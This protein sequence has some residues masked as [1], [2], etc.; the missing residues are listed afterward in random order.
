MTLKIQDNK[1]IAQE[2]KIDR[3]IIIAIISIAIIGIL[4]ETALNIAYSLLMNEFG[5]SASVIQWLTTGYLLILAILIPI[6]SFLVK[7]LKQKYYFKRELLF[8]QLE[9]FFALLLGIFLCY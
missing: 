5:M 7:S 9:H 4:S 1:V 2:Q 6:Y 8:L 3:K